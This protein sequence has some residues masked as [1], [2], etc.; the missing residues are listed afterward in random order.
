[1]TVLW[2]G[3]AV[4]VDH[5]GRMNIEGVWIPVDG[6]QLRGDLALVPGASGIVVFAHGSGSSRLSPRNRD[7]AR[8]LNALGL[9]TLLFD[10]LTPDEETIDARTRA[11]RFDIDLLARRLL[12]VVDWLGAQPRTA[13][14]RLGLFGAS[15]GAAAA[16]QAAAQRA[17]SV[18]AVVSR[19]GRPDL[20]SAWLDRVRAPTLLIVGGQDPEVLALNEQAARHLHG[21]CE[22]RI[23]AGAT[24][25]FEQPGAL[26]EVARLAG[27][28]FSSYLQAPSR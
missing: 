27:A 28:W 17:R 9:G 23:V 3:I 7:V 21:I 6:A 13:D 14:L 20:A 11:L 8:E 10:L 1:M 18:G 12:A 24:H 25:L 26:E 16:L 22:L 5:R 15:T 4:F 19:G 2:Q